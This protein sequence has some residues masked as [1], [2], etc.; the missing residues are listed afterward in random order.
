LRIVVLTQFVLKKVITDLPY[1]ITKD[2]LFPLCTEYTL[3]LMI[4]LL[5]GLLDVLQLTTNTLCLPPLG[6]ANDSHSFPP[7]TQP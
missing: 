7:N 5:N 6:Q 3:P 1:K 4:E 2:L